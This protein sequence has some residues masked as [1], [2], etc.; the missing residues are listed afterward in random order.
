MSTEL[1]TDGIGLI[2]G[3]GIFML[4]GLLIAFG[5]PKVFMKEEGELSKENLLMIK[6]VKWLG[7]TLVFFGAI[8]I[9]AIIFLP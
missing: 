7:L 8:V 1:T 9:I 3:T 4:F 2:I 6:W 5:L